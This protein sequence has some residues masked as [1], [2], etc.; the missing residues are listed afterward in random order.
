MLLLSGIVA[1]A[2]SYASL[3]LPGAN[4]RFDDELPTVKDKSPQTNLPRRPRRYFFPAVVAAAGMR[5]ELLRIV[6][7][8]VQCSTPGV[9]CFLPLL[10]IFY[11]I[12]PGRRPRSEDIRRKTDDDVFSQ[13]A[14]EDFDDWAE[15]SRPLSLVGGLLLAYGAY[16]A[17]RG[18]LKSTLFCS[19]LDSTTL[20]FG[21]QLGG[22]LLDAVIIILMWRILAWTRTT[23]SRLRTL[24]GIL[25]ASS[26]AVGFMLWLMRQ[27]EA[28]DGLTS[29]F[30]FDV[31]FDGFVLSLFIISATFVI[32]EGNPSTLVGTIVLFPALISAKQRIALAGTW[33][34]VR[35]ADSHAALFVL[36]VG[37]ATFAYASGLRSV[38]YMR[39]VLFLI[40]LALFFVSTAVYILMKGGTLLN[41]HPLD[42]IIYDTRIEADR[43]LVH[44]SVS[45]TL[46]IAVHQ[47][48]E[49]NHRRDPPPK[50]D[51][52]YKFATD[53][54]SAI[55]DHF[56]QIGH[57]I[58]PFWGL[59]PEK[60][61]EGIALAAQQPD[62]AIVTVQDGAEIGRAHV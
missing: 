41:D 31:I 48:Q 53:R 25:L 36:S 13:T 20:V 43:W 46:K 23:K 40:F 8:D 16:R 2:A 60:I 7:S 39:R 35:R 3:L 49:R 57:D 44:A 5:L 21:A 54:N 17:S 55:I 19:A 56:Q 51:M 12:L 9:E 28:S 34:N 26:V 50:F 27:Y 24:S 61:R 33:A 62:V 15:F 18:S 45:K 14:F 1:Y 4:G 11:E 59:S 32:C 52:W 30:V 29:L 42:S 22:L 6:S 47:Y 58:L 10:L 37:F 38:L